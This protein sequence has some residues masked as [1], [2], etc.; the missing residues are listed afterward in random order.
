MWERAQGL[1][2]FLRGC[3]IRTECSSVGR[4]IDCSV[5]YC[6]SVFSEIDWSLVRFRPLGLYHAT[7]TFGSRSVAF[8]FGSVGVSVVMLPCLFQCMPFID[9]PAKECAHGQTASPLVLLADRRESV[10]V[11]GSDRSTF[12]CDLHTAGYALGYYSDIPPVL[13][14][15]VVIEV[16][17]STPL[18]VCN[19]R[20]WTL[21]AVVQET[22]REAYGVSDGIAVV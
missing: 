12:L 18:S 9:T 22:L 3:W 10:A 8:S 21:T 16:D 20:R 17:R 19:G 6:V 4:A 14:T 7:R 13:A 15:P 2:L 5:L 1:Y 11:P